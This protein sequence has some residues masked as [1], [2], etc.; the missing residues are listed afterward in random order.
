M[1]TTHNFLH[2]FPIFSFEII[3]FI[4]SLLMCF[5]ALVRALISRIWGETVIPWT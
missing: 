3:L 2:T 1:V 5:G 4:Y